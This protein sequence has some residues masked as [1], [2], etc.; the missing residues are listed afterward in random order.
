MSEKKIFALLNHLWRDLN[1]TEFYWLLGALVAI[2]AVSWWLAFRLRRSS[3]GHA[4]GANGQNALLAFGAGSL[5]R[6]AFPLIA[7]ALVA[8]LRRT[9]AHAWGLPDDDLSADMYLDTQ[10][11]CAAAGMPTYEISNHARPGAESRHNLIYWRQG[12]WAAVGP[13]AHGR[14]SLPTG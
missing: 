12:D 11:I 9:L 10:E 1:T 8:L 5:K 7:L 13:G 4:H 2:L 3:H 14:L 6:L